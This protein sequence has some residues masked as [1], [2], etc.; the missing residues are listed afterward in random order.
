MDRGSELLCEKTPK[1]VKRRLRGS[2]DAFV[3]RV[4][5]VV[6]G[7]DKIIRPP[8]RLRE[9]LKSTRTPTKEMM[10]RDSERVALDYHKTKIARSRLYLCVLN[11]SDERPHSIPSPE[12][13]L[14]VRSFLRELC[15]AAV[16]REAF[17]KLLLSLRAAS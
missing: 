2:N 1:N 8:S 13:L 16:D 7:W 12:R 15:T 6:R 3:Q 17:R 14:E 9:T 4:S 5:K 10:Q 11:C